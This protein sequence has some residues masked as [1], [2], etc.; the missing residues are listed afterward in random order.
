MKIYLAKHYDEDFGDE[1][2]LVNIALITPEENKYYQKIA[3]D[4]DSEQ[5]FEKWTRDSTDN[6]YGDV[7][8]WYYFCTEDVGDDLKVGSVISDGSYNKYEIIERID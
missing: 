8:I 1:E 7:D 5:L 4:T 2:H 3:F 6:A